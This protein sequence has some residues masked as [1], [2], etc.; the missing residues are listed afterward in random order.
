MTREKLVIVRTVLKLR[1]NKIKK[2][3]LLIQVLK[4]IE[5]KKNLEHYYQINFRSSSRGETEC[6][7]SII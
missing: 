4:L 5:V 1:S 6:G 7:H 2:K 3:T